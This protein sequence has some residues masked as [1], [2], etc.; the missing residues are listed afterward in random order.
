MKPVNFAAV[1]DICLSN[2]CGKQIESEGPD[3][4]F[5][6]VAPILSQADL[7]FGNME[8]I[9]L[10]PDYPDDEI[11]KQGLVSKFDGTEALQ[12]AGFSFMNMASN[13]ILD[14]GE[15]GMFHTRNKIEARGIA[16]GGVG[17]NQEEARAIRVLAVGG[18]QFGFLCYCKDSSYTL[19]TI[20]PCHA[21]YHP[22]I[23]LEDISRHRADVDV[24]V[25]SVHADQEHV[26]TPS[27][28]RRREFHRF[29]E[30]GA[31]IVL[32]HHPHVPQG[33]E[34]IEN[35]LIAYSLGNFYFY[36]HTMPWHKNKRP[37]TAESFVLIART[38]PGKVE[39]FRRVP[40]K[41][42]IPPE[43]RPTP[44]EGAEAE[45]MLNY[46]SDL[47]QMCQNE[48]LISKNWRD[49]ALH[50]VESRLRSLYEDQRVTVSWQHKLLHLVERS[51]RVNSRPN[52]DLDSIFEK[53]LIPLLLT[54]DNQE[55]MEEIRKESE[56]RW[57]TLS[58]TEDPYHRPS[59]RLSNKKQAAKNA[60][61]G[62]KT[63]R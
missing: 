37:H 7:L 47:D 1:G 43:M 57:E 58:K 20:G 33:I 62:K 14:G 17:R 19:G 48:S 5:A 36:P 39:S 2:N 12:K 10:P 46:F 52:L 50:N 11:D 13:H 51:L 4:P 32:G 34:L 60:G 54:P 55:W 6:K 41:I 49:R 15:V 22:D 56:Q 59:Y 27:P 25:V 9:V 45:R 61:G 53:A 23:V 35:R 16:T 38:T 8:S 30:A 42:P 28:R 29:A 63:D 26:E 18:M 3:W 21:Y 24:L 40:V 44:C 31:T